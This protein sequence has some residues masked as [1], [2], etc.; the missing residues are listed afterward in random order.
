[1]ALERRAEAEPD[2]WEDGNL[3]ITNL[4]SVGFMIGCHYDM[5]H[6]DPL[7]LRYLPSRNRKYLNIFGYQTQT[8]PGHTWTIRVYG[9]IGIKKASWAG[10]S[11]V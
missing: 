7:Q 1:M 2:T 6:Y 9:S 11:L 5:G 8:P 10:G 4:G 3:G